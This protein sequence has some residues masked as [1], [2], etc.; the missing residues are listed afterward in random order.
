M[1]KL[2][3]FT[4]KA[5]KGFLK[6]PDINEGIY[7]TFNMLHKPALL[8]ILG[9]II[10]LS[11]Y[12]NNEEFPEYYQ[13]LKDIPIGIKP[14]HHE[15][16]NFQKTVIT[17]T[18]TTGFANNDGN[19]IIREQTLI[20]PSYQIFLLL[21]L[22]N[23]YQKQLFNYI[24]E[25]KAEFLPYLGKNDYSL[26]WNKDEVVEYNWRKVDKF[27]ESKKIETMFIKNIPL[28]DLKEKNNNF[29]LFDFSVLFEEPAFAYFERLPIYFDEDLY[30]YKYEDFVYTDFK[31]KQQNSL[32][33]IY[34]LKND[35][36]NREF[37]VQLN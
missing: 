4:I 30:Q 31:I 20:K 2:I 33:N 9:A 13:K 19:L 8:G 22:E 3:S 23:N 7:L 36:Y 12:K 28:K 18:N 14:V 17:Y 21:D 1:H 35:K 6:K 25:Q 24:K 26:W 5:E 37:Y 32:P 34:A 29:D 11:G 16:G 15:N 10:G 27:E